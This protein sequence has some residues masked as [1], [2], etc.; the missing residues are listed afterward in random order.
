[1][2]LLDSACALEEE[3]EFKAL[4]ANAAAEAVN[5]FRQGTAAQIGD[6]KIV[7]NA[8]GHSVRTADVLILDIAGARCV[9]EGTVLGGILEIFLIAENADGLIAVVS[10]VPPAGDTLNRRYVDRFG[11]LDN[12]IFGQRKVS[13][14]EV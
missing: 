8:V 3:A 7:N 13:A 9:Q 11:G 6:I 14:Q 10:V 2:Q 4:V 5:H 1:K 12:F